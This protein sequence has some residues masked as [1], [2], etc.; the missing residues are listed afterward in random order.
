MPG[1]AMNGRELLLVIVCFV[2]SALRSLSFALSERLLSTP[3][4]YQ[5]WQNVTVKGDGRTHSDVLYIIAPDLTIGRHLPTAHCGLYY[6]SM[7]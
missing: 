2:S 1:I 7:R 5:R 3:A 6:G 4:I